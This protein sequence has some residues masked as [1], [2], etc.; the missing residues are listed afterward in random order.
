MTS[1]APSTGSDETPHCTLSDDGTH[2]L[3][4]HNCVDSEFDHIPG[5][6]PLGGPG[7]WTLEQQEPLT[8]SPSIL[9]HACGTHGFFR[10]G[11]WMPV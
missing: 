1:G 10:E 8:I 7:G 5:R 11:K 2:F 6:L 4:R 3:W 9:C